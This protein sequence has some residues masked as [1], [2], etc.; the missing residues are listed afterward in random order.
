MDSLAGLGGNLQTTPTTH[1]LES[2][3]DLTFGLNIQTYRKVASSNTSC[4]EVYFRL[5]QIAYERN[6]QFLCTVCDL[7]TKS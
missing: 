7:L 3:K 6:F 4:L 1:T 2:I 5:F